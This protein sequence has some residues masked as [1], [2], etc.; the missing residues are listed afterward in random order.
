MFAIFHEEGNIVHCIGFA[1]T[2]LI[3]VRRMVDEATQ[4]DVAGYEV[5]TASNDESR[6]GFS[7]HWLEG[8]I[9]HSVTAG[10]KGG[11]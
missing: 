11:K 5:W 3:A 2:N 10:D 4:A 1:R 8:G 6:V 7:F 9:M